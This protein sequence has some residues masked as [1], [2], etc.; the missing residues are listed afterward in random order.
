MLDLVDSRLLSITWK[1]VII[2]ID[3]DCTMTGRRRYSSKTLY[4]RLVLVKWKYCTHLKLLYHHIL[5]AIVAVVL[6][7][8]FIGQANLLIFSSYLSLSK[9]SLH[10]HY[11]CIINVLVKTCIV[12][13][14]N[15]PHLK[16]VLNYMQIYIWESLCT[17]Y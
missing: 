15:T 10:R 12:C 13:I 5:C 2:S 6:C 8:S 1:R 17:V 16:A 7:F 14:I 9:Y 4:A 11:I 3:Y